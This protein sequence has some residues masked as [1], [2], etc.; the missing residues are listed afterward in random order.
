MYEILNKTRLTMAKRDEIL[1]ETRLPVVK[2]DDIFKEMALLMV[3][4]DEIVKVKFLNGS[5]QYY[6]NKLNLEN[7]SLTGD[8][9][10]Y[11]STQ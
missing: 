1:N 2:W 4:R 5:I 11:Q 10:L 7:F 3:K 9:Q 8:E 6:F